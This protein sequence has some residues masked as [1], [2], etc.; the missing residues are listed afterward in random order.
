MSTLIKKRKGRSYLRKSTG[1]N[2]FDVL[3]YIFMF[4]VL[5]ACTYPFWNVIMQSLTQ[6]RDANKPSLYLWVTDPSLASYRRMLRDADFLRSFLVT[7]ARIAAAWSIGIVMT[8]FL[9]YALSRRTLPFRKTITGIVVFTMFFNGG[10]IPTYIL[11]SD[12]KLLNNFWVLVL[13]G[14]V[15]TYNMIIMRN[16]FMSLPVELEE[17]AY[18]DG[19]NDFTIMS[20][21][22]VPLSKPI[23][24][25]VSLWI[26]VA[27]WN[28]WFDNL[29]YTPMRRDL[30]GLQLYLNQVLV[31]GTINIGANPW[32]YDPMNPNLPVEATLK[33]TIIVISTVPILVF[34]PFLQKYF[35]KGIIIGSLKG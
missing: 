27:H 1:E 23:L 32:E 13:P 31:A 15:S 18:I 22:Y 20:R 24:A 14:L 4:I 11:M 34:Y 35:V 21:I 25:T 33:A 6:P 8:T 12:L 7:F 29:I 28:S 3:N 19:A 16:Y 30:T 10:M 26:I 5:I 9:A 2:I 17:S